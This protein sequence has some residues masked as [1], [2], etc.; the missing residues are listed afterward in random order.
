[1]DIKSEEKK[2]IITPLR[3][4]VIDTEAQ[5][6]HSLYGDSWSSRSS[7]NRAL[8]FPNAIVEDAHFWKRG[9]H[10]NP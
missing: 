3:M 9:L 6:A 10:V 2:F 8:Q 4:M 1:L 5:R 7:L